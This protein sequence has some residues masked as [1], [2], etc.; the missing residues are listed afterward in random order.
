MYAVSGVLERLDDFD[1][2]LDDG[3]DSDFDRGGMGT[4]EGGLQ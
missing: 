1:F 3:L 2:N 4:V